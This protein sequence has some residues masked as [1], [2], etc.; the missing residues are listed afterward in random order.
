MVVGFRPEHLDIGE[1]GRRRRR[2]SGPVPTSS[3]TSAT[4]SCLHVNAADQD[5]VAIVGS[6]HRVRPGDIVNLV[7]PLDKVHLFDARDRS[8]GGA[9]LAPLA[10]AARQCGRG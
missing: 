6:E 4:R 7:L 2:R 10:A 9:R 5:I 8:L 1:A 3:S